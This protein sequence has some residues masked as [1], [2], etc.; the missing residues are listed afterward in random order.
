M[1]L[2][3]ERAIVLILIFFLILNSN[4]VTAIAKNIKKVESLEVQILI[5]SPMGWCGG[6]GR[7][8]PKE[9][10]NSP[11]FLVN[12]W[13][14]GLQKGEYINIDPEWKTDNKN[15]IEIMPN[16][17]SK[18]SVKV[19]GVGQFKVYAEYGGISRCVLIEVFDDGNRFRCVATNSCP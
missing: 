15:V 7:I 6:S 14:R 5:E 4:H 9:G 3:K 12:L 18:V 1:K 13:A 10:V 8:I 11:K 17:G 19:K 16:A 2:K